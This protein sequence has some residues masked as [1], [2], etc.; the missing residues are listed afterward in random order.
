V[1]IHIKKTLAISILVLALHSTCYAK[2]AIYS[3]FI[4][5]QNPGISEKESREIIAAVKYYSPRYF[6][7]G[8]EGTE[9]VLSLIATESSFRNVKGDL[10]KGISHGYMQIQKATAKDAAKFCGIVRP[11]DLSKLWDN[12]HLG[13]CHLHQLNKRYEKY[14]L[15]FLPTIIAYNNGYPSVD[16]WIRNGTIDNKTI[17]LTKVLS[18]KNKLNYIKKSIKQIK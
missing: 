8:T 1:K 14:S 10:D 5:S 9:W 13:M 4:K 7:E 6:G 2:D 11:F 17:Y 15:G 16:R 18:K 3:V 12:I